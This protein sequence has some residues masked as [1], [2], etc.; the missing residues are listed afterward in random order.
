M[1]GLSPPHLTSNV[2]RS[3]R[4]WRRRIAGPEPDPA[5]GSPDRPSRSAAHGTSYF[6]NFA[7]A[8]IAFEIGAPRGKSQC[9]PAS[10]SSL[11][12]CQTRRELLHRARITLCFSAAIPMCFNIEMRSTRLGKLPLS[13]HILV[14]DRPRTRSAPFICALGSMLKN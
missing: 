5:G 11:L 10:R 1:D 7:V 8:F 13:S 9:A 3:I 6:S 4:Q 14:K 12:A 2:V